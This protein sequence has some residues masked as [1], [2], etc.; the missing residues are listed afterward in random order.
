M[1]LF[2]VRAV[3]IIFATCWLKCGLAQTDTS[4]RYALVGIDLSKT[5]YANT[6]M[7]APGWVLEIQGR[8]GRKNGPG[9]FLGAGAYQVSKYLEVRNIDYSSEG[10]YVK[11]GI[12]YSEFFSIASLSNCAYLFGVFANVANTTNS[13]FFVIPGDYFQDYRQA[14]RNEYVQLG[15]Q[16]SNQLLFPIHK[17]FQVGVQLAGGYLINHEKERARSSYY[18]P[19]LGVT[20]RYRLASSTSVSLHY[21]IPTK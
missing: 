6:F 20:G 12:E 10:Q 11:F 18:A 4:S 7:K 17:H 13:G 16:I 9:L 15:V 8:T 21:L 19:G 2:F 5:L 14:F 1:K 3:I